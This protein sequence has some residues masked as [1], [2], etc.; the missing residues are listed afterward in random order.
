MRLQ[1]KV[2][3]VTGSSRGLGAAIARA[4]AREG[5]KVAVT[6]SKNEGAAHELAKDIGAA[7][8]MPLDVRDR[9]MIRAVYEKT[10]AVYGRL[11]ILVNNAGVNRTNDFDKQTDAEWSEVID[12]NLTG[13]FRCCQEVL[14]FIAD[15]GRIINI[16]SLSGQ[17]G[18]PRTPSYACAKAAL[19]ALTHNLARFLGPRGIC[20]NCL[21]PGV[22]GGEFTEKT[23]SPAVRETALS[24]MLLKRFATYEEMTGAAVYLAS[25]E[26]SYMTAQTVSVNGGAWV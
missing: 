11:D 7:L 23:M 24:L 15:K 16:G 17:Y 25:D 1:D 19:M 6:Y 12:V 22:I 3:V 2:A 20:V 14:P 26:S 5:C 13:V 4:F 10:V 9:G 8:V 21:S 18:G